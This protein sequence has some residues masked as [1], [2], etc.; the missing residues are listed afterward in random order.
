[1]LKRDNALAI[2]DEHAALDW[3][4]SDGEYPAGGDSEHLVGIGDLRH[5]EDA[6][7]LERIFDALLTI[8]AEFSFFR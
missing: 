3:W 4:A 7:D 5:T 2:D 6:F 1:M 8:Q